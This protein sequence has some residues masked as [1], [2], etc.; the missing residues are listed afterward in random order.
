MP[1]FLTIY[2]P[3]NGGVLAA[4]AHIAAATQSGAAMPGGWVIEA[5]G[6][7]VWEHSRI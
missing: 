1:G 7:D 5:E 3:A 4:A 2:L 6:L